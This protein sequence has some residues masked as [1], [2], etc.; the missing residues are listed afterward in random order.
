[1]EINSSDASRTLV[2]AD[3]VEALET[4]A[5]DGFDLV[6]GNQEVF[7]PA[8]EEMI[9]LCIVFESKAW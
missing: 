7:F 3:I 8:H 9:V 4:C 2:E 6:I 1:M 5:S